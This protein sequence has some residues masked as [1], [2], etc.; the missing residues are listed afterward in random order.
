MRRREWLGA[1]S[2]GVASLAGCSAL[3]P[4]TG[5]P[6]IQGSPTPAPVEGSPTSPTPPSSPDDTFGQNGPKYAS[7][8]DLRNL[9][10]TYALSPVRYRTDD[11]AE[12]QVQFTATGT[13]EHPPRLVARL[14]N[15]NPFENTFR[16]EWTPPFGRLAS[17]IPHP[18]AEPYH[19]GELTY[20][21]S[22][23][24]VP[25][26]NHELVD[27]SPSVTR[28]DDGIW[29][30]DTAVG[31]WLPKTVR[32]K[33]DEHVTGEYWL[34]GHP[35]GVGRGRPSGIYEFSRG[36]EGSVRLAVWETMQ[37]GPTTPSR[38]DGRDLPRLGEES[39]VAWFHHA[40]ETSPTYVS[41]STE[42]TSL[43]AKIDF[44][45]INR[46]KSETSCGHWDLHKIVGDTW[47]HLGPYVQTADCR[48]L[49]PG[50][51]KRWTLHAYHGEGL[52][53]QE[54]AVYGFL[55]GGEYGAVA[56]YG[57]ETERSAA[58]VELTG[59]P[60]RI[61]P[62]ADVSSER[63]EGTVTVTD[64]RWEDG[65]APASSTLT[66]TRVS[67]APTTVIPEQVMRHRFEGLRNTIAFFEEGVE[68][69]VLRTDER[70]AE[71]VVGYDNDARR[72][73]IESLDQAFEVRIDRES[74]S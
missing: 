12:I 40:E 49:P 23:V 15:A 52:A 32:L 13:A 27:R 36:G 59:E 19:A 38:F 65:E 16:L 51:A 26:A 70:I 62:T 69:V 37:P 67:T 25:T 43:P 72:F 4:S 31:E 50:S 66:V 28:D 17:D 18:P 44:M 21:S 53:C 56:G 60:V 2:A 68:K 46:S 24:F 47:Y 22:L 7:I 6:A 10:R 64:P 63:A 39:A 14:K 33:P 48:V 45:F 1:L 30:V 54:A 41:P 20:R 5:S 57:H 73:R 8:V 58:L 3:G 9:G 29:R 74:A 61:V 42:R 11:G 35:D 55:G 34:V 71:R